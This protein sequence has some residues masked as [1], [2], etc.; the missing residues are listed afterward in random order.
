LAVDVAFALFASVLLLVRNQHGRLWVG[1]G[2]AL[3][4][5]AFLLGL[6]NIASHVYY[7]QTV[8]ALDWPLLRHMLA[9][10]HDLALVM[11]GEVTPLQWLLLGIVILVSMPGP[12]IIRA[13]SIRS[14]SPPYL[15]PERRSTR[16]AAVAA[17]L[18]PVVL[19]LGLLPP[20]VEVKDAGAA[21]APVLYVA[22]TAFSSG[23][24]IDPSLNQA[25]A[26]ARFFEPGSVSVERVSQEPLRNL[27]VVVLE[28]TRAR[29][30]TPYQPT[31]LTS[32]FLDALSRKSLLVERAYAVLPSTAKAL[33]AIFCSVYPSISLEPQALNIGLL[34]GCLPKLLAEHGYQTMYMQAANVRF[35]NR[36]KAIPAMGFGTFIR[37]EDMS[38][39]GFEESNFLG[40]EDD[41]ML[42]PS[43]RWLSAHAG[44]PFFAAYL[45]INA[46]HD[47][48][49]LTRHGVH[50]FHPGDD[51]LDR[52][53]NNVHATDA[54]VQALFAQYE[55]LGV[56]RNTLFVLVA[57]HGE[58][59]G[60]HGRRAHNTV[61]YEEGLRIPLMFHDPSETLVRRG[62][63]P[64][65][66]SQLDIMPTVLQLLGFKVTSGRLHGISIFESPR[67][68]VLM[69][70]C[71]G[72]CATRI[73]EREAFIHHFGRRGD[74]LF[75][76]RNDP[77]E[78]RDLAASEPELVEQRAAEVRAFKLRIDSF[79][80]LHALHAAE[81]AA[82]ARGSR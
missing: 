63:V 38:S 48:N 13:W 42:E 29:A 7:M 17:M 51:V 47:Y 66:I 41:M 45:T 61:P 46:H 5:A 27:V 44:A 78:Q 60:E 70:S 65:P 4:A 26:G 75:N 31:L 34:G 79:F 64:G 53:L 43:E 8:D 77:L 68:R 33:T 11:A 32:P 35:E 30:L 56:Y 6:V 23:R 37:P 2:A 1:V 21:R 76:L 52:Y 62:R 58:A 67:D 72:G 19:V 24:E 25:V 16:R 40:R 74:E 71:M 15:G 14:G 50:H 81:A 18:S 80:Y 39:A 12:W 57:D 55:K 69:T 59:F 82:K 73:T 9:Q 54:F 22:A 20:G 36:V 49:R 10:P 28:S 3:Q